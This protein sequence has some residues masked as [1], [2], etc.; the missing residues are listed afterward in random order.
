MIFIAILILLIIAAQFEVQSKILYGCLCF[1]AF[2]MTV[3][4]TEGYDLS[5]YEIIYDSPLEDVESDEKSV[6]FS[7][8]MLLCNTF[9][10]SFYHFRIICFLL[11]SIPIFLF[12]YRCSCFPAWVLGLC[13]IFP[14]LT[15]GSQMRNGVAMGFVYWAF[16]LIYF[17]RDILG[18]IL[19]VLLLC[20]AGLIHNVA[21]FY[22]LALVALWNYV[23][24]DILLIC[25]LSVMFILLFGFQSGIFYKITAYFFGDYYAEFYFSQIDSFVWGNSHLFVTISLNA[26]F[27]YFAEKVESMFVPEDSNEWIFSH[28]VS[29]LNIV[30]LPA[31]ALLFVSFSFYRIYQNTLILTV[32]S[33]ANASRHYI[34]YSSG[35]NPLRNIYLVLVFFITFMFNFG[36][37]TF[38]EM[39]SSISL[40]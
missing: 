22:I 20:F 38:F 34:E 10:I 3:H 5:N 35:N 24:T 39:Y 28:F 14:I 2:I 19:F 26:W 18:K 4:F 23:R 12:I 11:W 31:M 29:R 30:L 32:L 25:C 16:L 27:A 40:F 1:L 33:V 15:F 36:Q 37:G 21:F 6:L 7:G 17:R 9:G 13:M 8:F